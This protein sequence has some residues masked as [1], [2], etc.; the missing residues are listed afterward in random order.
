MFRNLQ[1]G[2]NFI[3]LGQIFFPSIHGSREGD[4][5]YGYMNWNTGKNI[6]HDSELTT[7][8]PWA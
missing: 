2:G 7:S 3:T 5:W 4:R 8:V 1:Y 6:F